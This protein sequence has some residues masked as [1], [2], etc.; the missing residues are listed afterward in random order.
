MEQDE[1]K[2]LEKIY[3]SITKSLIVSDNGELTCVTLLHVLCECYINL[4]IG[5]T[6]EKFIEL[7]GNYYDEIKK[8]IYEN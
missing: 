7:C 5:E 8:G 4:C 3:D 2:E 1:K 6:K